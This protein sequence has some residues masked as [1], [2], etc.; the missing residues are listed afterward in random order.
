M[1]YTT[2]VQA[3]VVVAEDTDNFVMVPYHYCDTST[4]D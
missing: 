3:A 2:G 1:D 4:M